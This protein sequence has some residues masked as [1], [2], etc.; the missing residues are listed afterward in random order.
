MKRKLLELWG[1]LPLPAW[2]RYRMALAGARRFPVGVAAVAL[3]EAGQVLLFKHSYRGRH[4]WG[5]PTGWLKA[6]E[7]PDEAVVREIEEESGLQA[8][9]VRIL[10]AH[11]P[12][13]VFQIDLVYHCR[14]RPGDF[15]PSAEVIEIGWFNWDDLPPLMDF[16]YDMMG[17]IRG[18]LELDF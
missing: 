9:D 3:N 6:G 7:H 15:R 5:L 8:E 18:A 4:P 12:P 17:R 1:A 13:R 10:F 14:V 2:L 16:Q 11:H